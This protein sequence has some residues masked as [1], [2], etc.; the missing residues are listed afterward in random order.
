ML[1]SATRMVGN[2]ETNLSCKW[3]NGSHFSYCTINNNETNNYLILESR[4][5]QIHLLEKSDVLVVGIKT[6]AIK[7]DV[8][9]RPD[10]GIETQNNSKN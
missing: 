9:P 10:I 2:M 8:D 7:C 3:L 1:S 6:R 5:I 4:H